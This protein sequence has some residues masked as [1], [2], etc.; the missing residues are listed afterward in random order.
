MAPR[1]EITRAARFLIRIS[2]TQAGETTW[3][4]EA[5]N[6]RPLGGFF[7]AGAPLAAV[8]ITRDNLDLFGIDRD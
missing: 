8:A 1:A 3:T 7:P 2:S 4:G 5:D 6:W